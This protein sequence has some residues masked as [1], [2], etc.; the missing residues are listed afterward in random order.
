M[1]RF[2][3]LLSVLALVALVVSDAFALH[4]RWLQPQAVS[5]AWL[6]LVCALAIQLVVV[7]GTFACSVVVAGRWREP[8]SVSLSLAGSVT[9]FVLLAVAGGFSASL[10]YNSLVCGNQSLP[11]VRGVP[12]CA[13]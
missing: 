4:A 8:E 6:K 2:A 12:L 1:L 3:T 7:V 11:W 9:P 13:P 5:V 10:F